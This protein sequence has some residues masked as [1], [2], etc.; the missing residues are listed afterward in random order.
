MKYHCTVDLLFDWFGIDCMTT[1]NFSFYFQNRLIQT[2]QT[3]GQQYSDTS[4]LV[5]PT[6]TLTQIVIVKSSFL[7]CYTSAQG[8]N[9]LPFYQRAPWFVPWRWFM[10]EKEQE[11]LK[12]EVSLYCWPPVWLV[13]ISLFCKLKQKLSVVLQLIPNQSNRRSTVEWYFLL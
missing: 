12:G 6:F 3:G 13:W 10:V 8:C 1:D 2:S 4:P 7:T 9:F 11:I 5:F